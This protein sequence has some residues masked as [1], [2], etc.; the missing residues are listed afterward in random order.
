[1]VGAGCFQCET[2]AED[3]RPEDKADEERGRGGKL[4]SRVL[5]MGLGSVEYWTGWTRASMMS[6]VKEKIH[7][8]SNHI[9]LFISNKIS[10]VGMRTPWE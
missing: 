9:N 7:T 5:S 4:L 3:K 8:P 2:L 6:D 10:S 1:V